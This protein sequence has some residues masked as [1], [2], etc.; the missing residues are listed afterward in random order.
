MGKRLHRLS[1]R[2][3]TYPQWWATKNRCP[4]YRAWALGIGGAFLIKTL[5]ETGIKK[6]VE[7]N[8]DKHLE[9]YKTTLSKELVSLKSSLK[10]LEVFFVRQLEALNMLR[11]IFRK[12]L[13]KRR[14]PNMDWYEVCEEIANSFSKLAERL[15]E[16]RRAQ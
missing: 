2:N 4:P 5:V 12:V 15:H 1:M 14:T 9:T 3:E 11:S 13:P 8:F 7:L 10:N 6:T 16:G